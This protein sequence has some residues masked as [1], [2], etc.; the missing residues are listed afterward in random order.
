[1][2]EESK[3]SAIMD[4]CPGLVRDMAERIYTSRLIGENP[5][6][7]LHGG[8]NTSLKTVEKNL[9]GEDRAVIYVKGSGADLAAIDAEGFTALDLAPL[10]RLRQ[11]TGITDEE[12]DNQLKIHKLRA[13]APDPSVEALLHAFL[14]HKFIDHTHADAILALT[15]RADADAVVRQVLGPAVCVIPYEKSG[16]PLALSAVTAWEKQTDAEAIVVLNHGIFTFG[17]DAE[18]AF[19]RM[20]D[21]IA[22]AEAWL[23]GQPSDDSNWSAAIRDDGTPARIAQ[24]IRGACAGSDASGNPP[25]LLVDVREEDELIKVSM[26]PMAAKICEAGVLTPDHVIRT[27]N[28]YIYI[29]NVPAGDE[30][31]SALIRERVASWR[32]AYET[33]FN[34]FRNGS[35]LVML[36]PTPRIFLV[37]GVGL[38]ALGKTRKAARIAADIAAHTLLTRFRAGLASCV[39]IDEAHIFDMEYWPLQLKKLRGA[40]PALLEGKI[41]LVT[42]AAG[43]I[44]FGIADRL[45][46]AGATVAVSDIDETGLEIV[47][48][49]L[50]HRYDADRVAGISFDVTDEKSVQSGL[51]KVCLKFGGL[52]ILVPNAGVAHVAK[53]EDLDIKVFQ[54]VINVNLT[55]TVNVIKAAVPVFRRQ[56]TGGNIVLISTKNVFDPGASF[57][58]YS[59]SKAGAHQMARIAALELAELGVRVNM[60]N[61]DAVFGDENVPSKL[62]ALIGPDRMKARG[63]DPEGLKE[64]YRQRNL[65]KVSVSAQ[66]VGNA[67]VFFAANLTPTTGAALPVDGGVPAAFPR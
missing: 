39:P 34:A 56:K 57:G 31:L 22:R 41:A 33:G 11:L 37:A 40:P 19:R 58:A 2:L 13:D 30:D 20:A 42:G 5:A 4:A 67:V 64:Y 54:K 43:A 26:S 62:W 49:I 10:L 48:Q 52:D 12:M 46:A 44:G 60:I 36:D 53:I 45:L 15:S 7:V 18:T 8:G 24:M 65:L 55:G 6:W 47:R 59:A 1:M 23:N 25:T 38:F 17:E 35:D 14:P 9:F 16:L 66:H 63:L 28:R 3:I 29:D 51:E 61:P 27:G 32:A 50:A 21:F